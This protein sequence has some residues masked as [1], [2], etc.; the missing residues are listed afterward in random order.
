[1][2]ERIIQDFDPA[3]G[4][5]S[6]VCRYF[7]AARGDSFQEITNKK[8]KLVKRNRHSSNP[9]I[10]ET[11]SD[12]ARSV[13]G[14]QPQFCDRQ[15]ILTHAK[16]WH[17]KGYNHRQPLVSV[18]IPAYNAEKFIT[19][20]LK[21]VLSQTYANIEVIVVDDGSRDRTAEIVNEIAQTDSRIV[22]L[23]QP[24]SG[25]AAA[26]NLAIAN[27]SGEF[28]APIDADD[29]WYP[30]NIAKQVQCFLESDSDVGLVYS[31]S[32]DIDE[33]DELLG[34][35]RATEIEGEVYNTLVCHNFL[36]N[37]SA[38]MFRRSCLENDKFYCCDLKLQNAQGCEDWELYLRIA[39]NYQ[40]R[41][42]SEFLVGYRKLFNSMSG[43]Y[44]QMAKSH[45]LIMQTVRQRQPQLP[46]IV[47]QISSSN[48]Y[49]YFAHQSNRCGKHRVTW[50]WLYKA[51]QADF[52]TP[53]LRLGMYRLLFSSISGTVWQ[54][55]KKHGISNCARQQQSSNLPL[56]KADIEQQK[57]LISL[58]IIVGNLFHRVIVTMT[59]GSEAKKGSKAVF[60]ESRKTD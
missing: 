35:F 48:L 33:N 32:V 39:E 10:S 25:V 58:M 22:F 37:A 50:F 30:E 38:S 20:T 21:S 8:I 55:A 51:L 34:G 46:A 57:L 17:Q 24:N 11:N 6:V 2:C 1:M 14:W 26:R 12:K 9:P 41:V 4:L 29:I 3:Y 28:I 52:V 7:K 53:F 54:S 47:Y 31:W 45:D 56:T 43:D 36:G 13:L 59:N 40:F 15:D 49:M 18:I 42:V 60:F 16:N 27:S 5:E 44:S 19:R 23:Q